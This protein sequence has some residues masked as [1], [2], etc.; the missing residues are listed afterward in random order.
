MS[1]DE[2][3][4]TNNRCADAGQRVV[5]ARLC[6]ASRSTSTAASLVPNHGPAIGSSFH[7]AWPGRRGLDQQPVH[8]QRQPA[9]ARS[10]SQLLCSGDIGHPDRYRPASKVIPAQFTSSENQPS[11]LALPTI[12]VSCQSISWPVCQCPTRFEAADLGHGFVGAFRWYGHLSDVGQR[13]FQ[14]GH[15]DRFDRRG[16]LVLSQS[17]TKLTGALPKQVVNV[18]GRTQLAPRQQLVLIRFGSKLILVSNLQGEVRTL[19]ELTDPLEVDQM[20]YMR[21]RATGQY[22]GVLPFRTSQHRKERNMNRVALCLGLILALHSL[23]HDQAL[24][25]TSPVQSSPVQASPGTTLDQ[26][27]RDLLSELQAQTLVR[28]LRTVRPRTARIRL[29]AFF[30]RG[31]RSGPVAKGYRAVYRSICC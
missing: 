30:C 8:S 12:P 6:A 27:M 25:Q 2:T 13:I 17:R 28:A 31:R 29:K 7:P 26:G 20:R 14:P 23:P 4:E 19:S 9:V 5:L 1:I 11:S 16:R 22:L 24:A 18:L 10:D 21:E 15:R 3:H